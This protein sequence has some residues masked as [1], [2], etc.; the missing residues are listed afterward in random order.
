M[1]V[2]STQ[3]RNRAAHITQGAHPHGN[4]LWYMY[5]LP[6]QVYSNK[7]QKNKNVLFKTFILQK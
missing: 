2:R 7:S 5:Y 4:G 3:D 1:A 6:D